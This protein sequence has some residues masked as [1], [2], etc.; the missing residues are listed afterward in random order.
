MLMGAG[1]FF[2]RVQS[3]CANRFF[4]RILLDFELLCHVGDQMTFIQKLLRFFQYR[5]GQYG[6]TSNCALCIESAGA[7]L[8]VN[9]TITLHCRQWDAKRP[10][11]LRLRAIAICTE[12]T[13]DHSKGLQVIHGMG[14]DWCKA[15]KI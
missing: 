7:L 9:S 8:L 11:D 4:Q 10:H 15:I 5:R 1:P 2:S 3:F 12:L 6:C 13:R 14:K